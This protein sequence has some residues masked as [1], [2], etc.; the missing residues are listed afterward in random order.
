MGADLGAFLHHDDGNVRVDL[1]EAD[2]GGEPGG[3]GADDHDVE[4]HRLAGG[5]FGHI[6]L[7]RLPVISDRPMTRI[8]AF[9]ALT[10]LTPTAAHAQQAPGQRPPLVVNDDTVAVV[11]GTI[12]PAR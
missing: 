8:A 4:F 3:A 2:G 7:P 5:Q 12:R 11:R 10:P 1:L 6:H 9:A